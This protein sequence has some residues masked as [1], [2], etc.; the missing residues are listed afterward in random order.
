MNNKVTEV[1]EDIERLTEIV[2]WQ[3]GYL[4]N[5]QNAAM[6]EVLKGNELLLQ[7][8]TSY[9]QAISKDN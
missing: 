2:K 1:K 6:V 9:L 8:A 7:R 3:R 5:Y 4:E